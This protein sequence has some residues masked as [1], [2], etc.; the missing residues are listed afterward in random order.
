MKFHDKIMLPGLD[1]QIEFLIKH[2]DTTPSKVL[3]CGSESVAAAVMIRNV[4][5]AEVDIIV[6]DFDSLINTNLKLDEEAGI[7][8]SL[9]EFST[10]DFE[11]KNFDLIYA[12]ASITNPNRNK[13]IK[14]YKRLLRPGGRICVGELVLL[15]KKTP[16]YIDNLFEYSQMQ[17]LFVDDLEKYYL[18]RGFKIMVSKNLSST[19]RE[20]YIIV[21]SELEDSIKLLSE[22]EKSYYKKLISKINHESNIYLHQ[23]GEK[24]YGF[25]TLLLKRND[26][27]RT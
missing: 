5:K 9:M 6:E 19:L 23:N 26:D 17:P 2:L 10:T 25:K 27:T 21:S 15:D 8:S 18:E 12:Q 22:D 24:Y 3:V 7:K 16:R 20:Y 14:E 13:I 11:D 4:L 1:K